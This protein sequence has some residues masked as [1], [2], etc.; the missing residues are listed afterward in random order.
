MLL[1]KTVKIKW[2]SKIKKHYELL[3]YNYTKMGDEII[4]KVEDLTDGSFVDIELQCDYCKQNYSKKW[5][6]YIKENK[7]SNIH[8]DCCIKCRKYKIQESVQKT[9]GVNSVLRLDEIKEQIKNT[10]IEKYGTENPFASEKIKTKIR[11][12]NLERYGTESA[13][14][15]SEIQKKASDTCMK[16]YGVKYYVQTQIF[17]GEDSPRW[18]GGVAKIRSERFTY[19]YMKW[20]TEVF[21][22]NN[23]T[24]QCCQDKSGNGKSI[25]L[26]AHHIMNWK[27]NPGLRFDVENGITLCEKCHNQFHSQYGKRYNTKEQIDNFLLNNGKKVC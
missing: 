6:N 17:R 12:T 3:G 24:C 21:S 23:Y 11:G 18:K 15:N 20:R 9:Y 16:R 27:D 2:N 5:C 4:V 1:S 7:G 10:N 14:Q 19:D 25:K 13:M 26:N 8:K 22:K